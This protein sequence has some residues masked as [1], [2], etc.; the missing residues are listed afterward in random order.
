M[1]A[2]VIIYNIWG[3]CSAMLICVPLQAYWDRSIQ[4]DCK[5][6]SYMWAA[7]GL[8]VATDFLIFIIP[9]PV[10]LT[11]MAPMKRQKPGLVL[12]FA[13]GFLCACSYLILL[14]IHF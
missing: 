6:V 8:H 13:L 5:P 11:M 2:V 3:F 1:L 7:I 12:I 14:I 4:G 9:I 10:V